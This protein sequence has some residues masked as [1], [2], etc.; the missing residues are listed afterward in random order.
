MNG[1]NL[2]R[3]EKKVVNFGVGSVSHCPTDL[4]QLTPEIG[5]KCSENVH[6]LIAGLLLCATE[7]VKDVP[8]LLRGSS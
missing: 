1:E 5:V 3:A 6:Q 4:L 7:T 8:N 2:L